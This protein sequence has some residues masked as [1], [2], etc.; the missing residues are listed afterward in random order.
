MFITN[1]YAQV[2]VED[3]KRYSKIESA[4]VSHFIGS[5]S[6]FPETVISNALRDF[7]SYSDKEQIIFEDVK[8]AREVAK[9]Q[10]IAQNISKIFS[11]DINFDGE[12]TLEEASVALQQENLVNSRER[13]NAYSATDTEINRLKFL[14]KN[15]DHKISILEAGLVSK[16]V[17][18]QHESRDKLI[19]KN[20]FLPLDFDGNSK[21]SLEEFRSALDEAVQIIDLNSDNKF[22]KEELAAFKNYWDLQSKTF[23]KE[24]CL[25]E[26][27]Q[28]SL[29]AK[30]IYVPD[31]YNRAASTV[32]V[33]GINSDTEVHNLYVNEGKSPL[34]LILSDS[35]NDSIWNISGDTNRIEHIL[36]EGRLDNIFGLVSAGV[37]GIKDNSKIKFVPFGFCLSEN[38]NSF[39]EK[40]IVINNLFLNSFGKPLNSVVFMNHPDKDGNIILGPTDKQLKKQRARREGFDKGVW[41]AF[42]YYSQEGLVDISIAELISEYPAQEYTLLPGYAGLAQ[43][44]E[45]K[46]L[47]PFHSGAFGRN[48]AVYEWPNGE[49]L[50]KPPPKELIGSEKVQGAI[51]NRKTIS[52]PDIFRIIEDV[53]ELPI[54]LAGGESVIFLTSD[55]VDY[56]KGRIG[57]SCFAK[58][59]KSKKPEKQTCR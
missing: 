46:K 22:S 27:P 30:I 28:P 29:E 57:H 32:S 26:I 31:F 24:L 47:Q 16:W 1:A 7:K 59:D 8:V 13:L 42:T 37:Y 2:Q 4:I 50:S 45:E 44:V 23:N 35:T 43:L 53:K 58:E 20:L 56:P 49:M 3:N 5:S 11:Y 14:D 9:R 39:Q 52:I 51:N 21:V 15:K 18:F 33:G 34:Y 6:E 25:P 19:S 40:Q 36:V 38:R 17:L 12:V 48:L 55:D 54:G 10:L 41:E